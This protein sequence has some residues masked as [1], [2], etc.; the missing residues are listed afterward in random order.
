MSANESANP[1]G[2]EPP[3]R[4]R[5]PESYARL[6]GTCTGFGKYKASLRFHSYHSIFTIMASF[7]VSLPS[8]VATSW[9]FAPDGEIVGDLTL[10][11]SG[12]QLITDAETKET[13]VM[14][15]FEMDGD[16]CLW[17]GGIVSTLGMDRL[18]PKPN[19]HFDTSKR[20][21]Y[22][23]LEEWTSRKATPV[24]L[25]EGPALVPSEPVSDYVEAVFESKGGQAMTVV[26]ICKGVKELA[27]SM[28]GGEIIACVHSICERYGEKK[29]R[30]LF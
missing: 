2:V 25:G 4:Y 10:A 13:I 12:S 19:P 20:Q 5:G 7:L 8:S 16:A 24:A 6:C 18:M 17:G 11:G 28:P 21:K 30:L 1:G 26:D 23:R 9:L 22:Q 15:R 29:W 27:P 3:V 14:S